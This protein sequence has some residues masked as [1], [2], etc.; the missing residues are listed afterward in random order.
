MGNVKVI[1][2]QPVE[3]VTSEKV[4]KLCRRMLE[5]AERGELISVSFAGELTSR[6]TLTS[7]SMSKGADYMRLI[8]ACEVAKQRLILRCE[9][10]DHDSE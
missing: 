2:L 7:H 6:R 4:I 1:D 3:P 9:S 8:G 5:M 10:E